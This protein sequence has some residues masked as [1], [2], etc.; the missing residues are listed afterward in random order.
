MTGY[1]SSSLSTDNYRISVELK[2]LNSKF[3]EVNMKLPRTYMQ[4]EMELRNYLTKRLERG[5]VN[6]VMSV[7]VVNPELNKLRINHPLVQAYA[8]E[9]ENLRSS[10][11]LDSPISLEYILSL[12]DAILSDGGDS[13]KEELG[14]IRQGFEEACSRLLESRTKEGDAT[15]KDFEDCR[16]RIAANLEEV[17]SMLPNRQDHIRER[18]TQALNEVKDRT[19]VDENRYEQELIYYIEKF[20]VNEEIVRLTKHLEYFETTLR[21]SR[22]GGKKLGFI[23][24][25][26]GREINTIGSKAND[27]GIQVCVVKMKEDLER[28]KEQ[29]L[30]IV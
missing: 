3:I 1:G 27:A 24:Q 5:K 12:P 23:A 28:I 25:E 26:I 13:D 9:L 30:N 11:Q 29:V 17:K 8:R 18:L 19:Q 2:S 4:L 16:D 15:L 14:L 22:S 6:V 10:L 20:D 7:E 21:E